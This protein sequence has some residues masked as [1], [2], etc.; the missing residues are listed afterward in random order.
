MLSNHYHKIPA[1]SP[2]NTLTITNPHFQYHIII[3]SISQQNHTPSSHRQHN[4]TIPSYYHSISP[5]HCYTIKTLNQ[6]A[7]H[8]HQNT[9]SHH[10]RNKSV[11]MTELRPSKALLFLRPVFLFFFFYFLILV[12]FTGKPWERICYLSDWKQ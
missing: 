5:S 2:H 12:S 1:L 6:H 4:I 7:S 10:H 8:Y 11:R 3:T 9:T